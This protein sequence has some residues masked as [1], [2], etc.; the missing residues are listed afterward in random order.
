MFFF[1]VGRLF[2]CD[3]SGFDGED[4]SS[5]GNVVKL[6]DNFDSLYAYITN[7]GR[8]FWFRTNMQASKY[9][10][11]A[12]R[13]SRHSA[14]MKMQLPPVG[15]PMEWDE[16]ALAAIPK[17][18]VVPE[19]STGVLTEVSAVAG[20]RLV[21][22]FERDA[23]VQLEICDLAG[24]HRKPIEMPSI[25]TIEQVSAEKKHDHIFLKF[26]NFVT[27]GMIY[28]GNVEKIGEGETQDTSV[29][30]EVFRNT[31]V[32]GINVDNFETK[33]VR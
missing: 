17:T 14:V 24:G 33:Q 32:P 15:S 6:V 2:Y 4:V 7:E 16:A 31:E 13:F 5:M 30:L 12:T 29:K 25:G 9:K 21:L 1:F 20:D 26:T 10:A 18:T 23:Y 3:L 8:T 28:G 27:P 19:D 11:S 22:T